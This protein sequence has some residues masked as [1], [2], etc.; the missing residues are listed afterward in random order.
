M[1]KLFIAWPIGW[2]LHWEPN[3][4]SFRVSQAFSNKTM[5]IRNDV[6]ACVDATEEGATQRLL[7][8]AEVFFKGI[9]DIHSSIQ[10][11][12]IRL[13]YHVAEIIDGSVLLGD[14]MKRYKDL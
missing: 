6:E 4:H 13:R 7:T 3:R 9:R 2:E 11:G 5:S 10:P 8:K 14:V 1:S 12:D